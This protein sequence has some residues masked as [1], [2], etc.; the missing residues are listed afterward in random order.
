MGCDAAWPWQNP[1]ALFCLV[2]CTTCRWLGNFSRHT[3]HWFTFCHVI[4]SSHGRHV[5]ERLLSRCSVCVRQR[6]SYCRQLRQWGH[7]VICVYERN[8]TKRHDYTDCMLC[9]NVVVHMLLN[10]YLVDGDYQSNTDFS[11][12]L[13][14]LQ[15]RDRGDLRNFVEI[16]FHEIKEITRLSLY[17]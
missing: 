12:S 9:C 6:F 1:P 17:S 14:A 15:N 16:K 7:G 2:Y 5:H 8:V 4:S 13:T 11:L 3:T 10:P